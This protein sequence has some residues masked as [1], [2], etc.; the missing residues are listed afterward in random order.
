MSG[1]YAE[2][3]ELYSKAIETST[4]PNCIYFANRANA[5]LE[6]NENE[7]CLQD[8]S[9]ALK[10]DKTYVKAYYRKALALYN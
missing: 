10:I 1:N 6:L 4:T 3:V 8:C 9:E 7:K 5:Y 2:A